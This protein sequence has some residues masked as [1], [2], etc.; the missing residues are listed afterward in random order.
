MVIRST[1]RLRALYL[2]AALVIVCGCKHAPSDEEAIRAGITQHLASLKTLNI[3]AMDLDINS[4]SMQGTQAHVQV[5]FRPKTGAPPGAGMQVAYQLE[6]RDSGWFV[7]KT[8]AVGGGIQH[9]AADANP[10]LQTG[11]ADAHGSMPNFRELIPS[12][13][14]SAAGTL[15]PGHPPVDA[16]VQAKPTDPNAKPK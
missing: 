11:Q 3:S 14:P 2:V 1:W 4:I 15:P 8:D 13:T 16:P 5:T 6:K 7:V 10:H 9:P 12:T